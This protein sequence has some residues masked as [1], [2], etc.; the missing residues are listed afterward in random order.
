LLVESGGGQ[1][2]EA[3]FEAKTNLDRL[4]VMLRWCASRA[5]VLVK[6]GEVVSYVSVALGV[7]EVGVRTR[8]AERE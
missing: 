4:S 6:W 5:L 1:I 2:P 3:S 7:G 8:N